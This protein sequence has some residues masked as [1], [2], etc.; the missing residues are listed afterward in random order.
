MSVVA[1][2]AGKGSPGATTAAVALAAVWPR[3]CVLAECDPAGGDVLFRLRATGGGPLV[4]DRGLVS[5][6]TAA[7]AGVTGQLVSEHAQATE[8]GLPV[9]VGTASES[10]TAALAGGWAG[11]SAAFAGS[12]CDVVVDL[13]RLS[14]AT[15]THLLRAA[16]LVVVVCRANAASVGHAR[17]A[18]DRLRREQVE[19]RV[20]VVGHGDDAVQVRDA[21]RGHGELDVLGP[22]ADDPAGAA[23]LSGQW[24]RRLDRT[25]LV[26]SARLVARS[27]DARLAERRTA[28]SLPAPAAEIAVAVAGGHVR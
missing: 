5:L 11:V 15:P 16:D 8:G 19:P 25:P 1:V 2:A 9:L 21:L 26:A 18:L 27:L 23:G 22:L 20:L 28:S 12:D 4:A 3:G 17:H 14:S 6:A 24:T 7:R 10:H 13:G